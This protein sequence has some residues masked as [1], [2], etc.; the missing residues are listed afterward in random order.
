MNNPHHLSLQTRPAAIVLPGS[1]ADGKMT[2]RVLEVLDADGNVTGYAC[3]ECDRRAPRFSNILGH[4]KAHS[5]KAT[6]TRKGAGGLNEF[7][8]EHARLVRENETLAKRL[9]A[10]RSAR[11]KVERRLRLIEDLFSGKS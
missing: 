9:K 4:L 2:D 8:R 3:S 1:N 10:E 5:T 7:I 11:A 6:L